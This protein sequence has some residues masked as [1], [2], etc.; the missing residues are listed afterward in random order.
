MATTSTK[1]WFVERILNLKLPYQT[2]TYYKPRQKNEYHISLN[3]T[4]D[5]MAE[6]RRILVNGLSDVR[7]TA[8]ATRD[9]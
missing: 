9:E 8:P 5:E 7:E 6:L 1:P 4:E 2:D 3:L